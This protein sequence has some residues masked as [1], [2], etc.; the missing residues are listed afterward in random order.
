MLFEGV[1]LLV[2]L[3]HWVGGLGCKASPYDGFAYVGLSGSSL[4]YLSSSVIPGYA[5]ATGVLIQ[6]RHT[7]RYPG[8]TVRNYLGNILR[9][10]PVR[11][12]NPVK[13]LRVTQPLNP[14]GGYF[15]ESDTENDKGSYHVGV[16]VI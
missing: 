16:F 15:N 10:E 3:C 8:R 12:S 6:H 9:A 4:V 1:P 5:S 2:N 11:E 13:P 14:P 7:L